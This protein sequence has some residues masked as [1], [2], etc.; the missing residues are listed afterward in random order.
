MSIIS[1]I[2]LAIALSVDSLAVSMSG[3]VSMGRLRA[4]KVAE[5]TLS[6]AFI[7]TA[8]LL[9]G[10]F[11]G[12]AVST[13]ISKWGSWIGFGLLM[14][15]GGEMIIEAI[16]GSEEDQR[17]FGSPWKI[18]VAAVATSIDAVAVGASFGLTQLC[19]TDLWATALMTF[20][21][22]IL[23]AGAGMF[24]GSAIGRKFG[25]PA[26]LCAGIVLIVIGIQLLF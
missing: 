9:G 11:A 22:T 19:S 10:Y 16:R 25:R 21:A 23:F 17:D 2:L 20:I 3:A 1:I 24:C 4:G 7:Q 14:Y 5:V 15:V 26:G 6:L 13:W 8:F 12:E 18:I